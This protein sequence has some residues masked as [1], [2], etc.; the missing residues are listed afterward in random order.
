MKLGLHQNLRLEQRLLQ[1]PQMIQA[2]QI[3]QLPGLELRE[4]VERELEENPFLEVVEPEAPP[5][6]EP[7]PVREEL[8]S[9]GARLELIGRLERLLEERPPGGGG[10]ARGAHDGEEDAHYDALLN[11]P[12]PHGTI[13]DRLLPDLRGEE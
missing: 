2:M 3:L 10:P 11:A 6:E 13:A 1:S 8:S 9:D 7:R 4:R 12:D 5:A